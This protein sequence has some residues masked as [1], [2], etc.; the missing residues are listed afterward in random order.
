MKKAFTMIE[1]IFV[2]VI[3]GILAAIAI[4]KLTATR[5]DASVSAMISH[6]R[7]TLSDLSAY[8]TSQGNKM[9]KDATVTVAT[10]VPLETSCGHIIDSNTQLS[11]N[12]F[13]LCSDDVVCVSFS[14]ID[15]G[16]LTITNGVDTTSPICEAVKSNPAIL[17]L[18][19]KNFRLGGAFVLR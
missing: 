1:L 18:S 19:N 9:W 8:Y 16:N 13:V 11:P 5:D 10:S 7:K 14:S 2:I 6:T 17:S 15:E 12:T 4:P 3:I